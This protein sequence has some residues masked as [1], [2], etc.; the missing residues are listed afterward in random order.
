MD[1]TIPR[2]GGDALQNLKL[3]GQ[4]NGDGAI[5]QRGERP[6]IPTLAA[7]KTVAINVERHAGN[8][9]N[10]AFDIGGAEE[11]IARRLQNPI[12]P[13]TEGLSVGCGYPLQ[14]GICAE[15]RVV[16]P[17]APV[18]GV[19]PDRVGSDLIAGGAV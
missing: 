19:P 3:I 17:L 18:Y 9:N 5:V 11:L 7:A 15:P 6:V 13:R 8:E 2:F 10:K 12:P 1:R 16:N 14:S 4:R